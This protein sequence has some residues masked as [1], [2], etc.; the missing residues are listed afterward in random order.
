M[1]NVVLS[2]WLGFSYWIVAAILVL[3]LVSAVIL[4]WLLT[5]SNKEKSVSDGQTEEVFSSTS[6]NLNKHGILNVVGFISGIIAICLLAGSFWAVI[7]GRTDKT[8]EPVISENGE[9]LIEGDVYYLGILP[10][11]KPST[12]LERFSGVEKYLQDTTGLNIKLRL[13][14]TSGD[15]GGYTAVVKDVSS[16]SISF[17]YLAS[18]TTVQANGNGPVIPFICAQKNGLPTYQGDLV[19][20]VDSSYQTLADLKDK[21]VSGTSKSST[22]GNL[23][24]SAM[25][26]QADIDKET[27]F[28]GGMIYLG[29]HDKAAEAVL[30]GIIDAAFINEATL[31]KYNK[32]GMV[33]RSVWKHD[34]VPEF[35][36]VVNTET[37]SPEVLEKV[38]NA[39]LKMH[40]TNLTGIQSAN[41]NYEKWVEINWEDYLS[42]KEAIDEVYGPVFYNLDEWGK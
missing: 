3:T 36:F 1:T 22:S 28:D 34:P 42:I 17:A 16:G 24:P 15:V 7:A 26:K 21:K 31:N 41:E 37:V 14:S 23:M 29:S 30:A 40:E 32:D 4:I 6:G 25:L 20:K 11:R 35:P 8:T 2:V 39:L 38:K 10:L 9:E 5:S 12:M 27:Y 13:Y 33:L 19:V 18:V